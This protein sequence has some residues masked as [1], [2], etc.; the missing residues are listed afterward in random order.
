MG[1]LY[2][3]D[4]GK[5]HRDIKAANVLLSANGAVKLGTSA[6]SHYFKVELKPRSRLWRRCPTFL[7]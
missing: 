5:I 4:E 7:S 1:L 2:L 3:H 6:V